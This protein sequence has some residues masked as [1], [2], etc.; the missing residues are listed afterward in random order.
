MNKHLEIIVFILFIISGCN[1]EL[2]TESDNNIGVYCVLETGKDIQEVI[3]QSINISDGDT[4]YLPAAGASVQI[5]SKDS[6]YTLK[7]TDQGVYQ[8]RFKPALGK[9]YTLY[10][11][12]TD[13]VKLSSTIS[14]PNEI[15]VKQNQAAHIPTSFEH[16]HGWGKVTL[17]NAAYPGII[18]TPSE[19]EE[20]FYVVVT[21]ATTATLRNE[22][23]P[24][25][26]LAT[27][28]TTA[29]PLTKVELSTIQQEL[30]SEPE[31]AFSFPQEDSSISL[32]F[33]KDFLL[34][35]NPHK[36]NSGRLLATKGNDNHELWDS[37]FFIVSGPDPSPTR[38]RISDRSAEGI[39][40]FGSDSCYY[41]LHDIFVTHLSEKYVNIYKNQNGFPTEK[42]DP[43]V[44]FKN[45]EE[46]NI[47]GGV[48]LFAANM[49]Y[50][51]YR[52]VRYFSDLHNKKF[53]D[54]YLST[55]KYEGE[56]Y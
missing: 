22:S 36:F 47:S 1:P 10:V 12:T 26:Y 56:E 37:G 33:Y 20:D 49:G 31:Y 3:V 50:V 16:A 32:S 51:G 44:A 17:Y 15:T 14:V 34:I 53:R 52:W 25:K 4:T 55:P 54:F 48:G 30:S 28:I 38:T 6:I 43:I 13:G 19:G 45:K 35:K 21:T 40:A 11:T 5:M 2:K 27:N 46:S 7:E 8:Y 42:M 29:D 18:I 39:S 41:Y 9:I 24:L 23:I